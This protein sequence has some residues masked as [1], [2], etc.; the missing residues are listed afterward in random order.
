MYNYKAP[1][2]WAFTT[3][4]AL[5]MGPHGD[6]IMEIRALFARHRPSS[7]SHPLFATA[8][9]ITDYPTPGLR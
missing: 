9:S 2:L 6:V 1:A 3:F 4:V 5:S 8:Q 7:I